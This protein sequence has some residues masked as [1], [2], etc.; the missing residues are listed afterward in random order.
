LSEASKVQTFAASNLPR[1]N[2]KPRSPEWASAAKEGPETEELTSSEL[3]H[4]T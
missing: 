2:E 4:G 1:R 3:D